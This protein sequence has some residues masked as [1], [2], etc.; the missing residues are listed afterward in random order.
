[1]RP[2]LAHNAIHLPTP[3]DGECAGH[4]LKHLGIDW[5]HHDMRDSPVMVQQSIRR[6]NTDLANGRW[7]AED[8]LLT[9][10]HGQVRASTA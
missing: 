6:M 9:V 7:A 5:Q 1:M 8:D 2:L 4:C 10:I 3:A